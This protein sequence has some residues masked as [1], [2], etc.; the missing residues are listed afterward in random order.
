MMFAMVSALYPQ[1]GLERRVGAWRAVLAGALAGALIASVAP[2]GLA[3]ARDAIRGFTGAD[4]LAAPE[5]QAL[6]AKA[7]PH[8]PLPLEW[9]WAPRGFD[10]DRM[11]RRPR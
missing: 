2:L 1:P 11:L 6:A 10:V 5:L 9:R 7:W 3:V 8:R 4:R